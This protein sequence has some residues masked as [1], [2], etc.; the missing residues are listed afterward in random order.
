MSQLFAIAVTL[1]VST[2]VACIW[3]SLLMNE[4]ESDTGI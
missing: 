2:V 1:I 3:A 4:D